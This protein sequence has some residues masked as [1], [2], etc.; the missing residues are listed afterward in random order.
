MAKNKTTK[1]NASTG[2]DPNNALQVH[3]KEGDNPAVATAAAVLAPGFRH[4][5]AALQIH[6]PQLGKVEG[7]PGFGDYAEVFRDA[8]VEASN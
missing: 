7:A 5:M 3:M 6:K 1:G 4:G 2:A 8:G